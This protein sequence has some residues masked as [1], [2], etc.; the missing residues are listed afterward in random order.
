MDIKA[1][2]EEMGYK[3]ESTGGNCMAYVKHYE[4]GCELVIDDGDYALPVNEEQEVRISYQDPKTGNEYADKTL[5]S[6]LLK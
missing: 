4:N 5:F 2:M 3:A 6:Y 1:R